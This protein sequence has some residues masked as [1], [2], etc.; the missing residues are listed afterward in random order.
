MWS[1]YWGWAINHMN[2]DRAIA[3]FDGVK[4]RTEHLRASLPTHYE[5]LA[6]QRQAIGEEVRRL[7]V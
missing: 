5:Y 7:A 4:Q 1:C 6:Q 2:E 3:A